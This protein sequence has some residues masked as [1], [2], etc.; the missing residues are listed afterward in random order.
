MLPPAAGEKR[1]SYAS[2]RARTSLGDRARLVQTSP[3]VKSAC[4][5]KILHATTQKSPRTLSHDIA[6]QQQGLL[7]DGDAIGAVY[8]GR[9]F[10]VELRR[11]QGFAQAVGASEGDQSGPVEV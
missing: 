8:G 3:D 6:W 10:R 2:P 1:F 5:R 7:H 9:R 11:E 4:G